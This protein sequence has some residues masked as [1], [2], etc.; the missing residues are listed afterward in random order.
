M[1]GLKRKNFEKIKL[2]L[3]H[4][5]ILVIYLL[6]AGGA[7]FLPM[8]DVIGYETSLLSALLLS[9]LGGIS[10]I[11]FFKIGGGIIS[12][13]YLRKKTWPFFFIL[14]VVSLLVPVAA[15][16][17]YDI[18]PD[19]DGILFHLVISLP[20]LLIGISLGTFWSQVSERFHYFK[21]LLSMLVILMLTEL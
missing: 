9:I 14:F 10:A 11:K 13:K 8:L 19:L 5:I 6:I 16:K 4:I 3:F 1:K 12:T 18:C 2:S 15:T 17:Y 7:S 20:S 21:F